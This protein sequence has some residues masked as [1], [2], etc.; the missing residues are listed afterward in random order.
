MSNA[1]DRLEARQPLVHKTVL[2]PAGTEP[3]H[4]GGIR[5]KLKR[6]ATRRIRTEPEPEP[7]RF[8]FVPPTSAT[9]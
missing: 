9:S 8:S 4:I 3:Q 5:A 1:L 2:E 6:L 7:G